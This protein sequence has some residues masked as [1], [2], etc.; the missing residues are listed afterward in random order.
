MAYGNGYFVI[1]CA[2]TEDSTTTYYVYY[3]KT[4]NSYLS[5]ISWTAATITLSD[6]IPHNIAYGED[7]NWVILASYSTSSYY[8]TQI[9]T[10]AS[11]PTAF[12]TPISTYA[13]RSSETQSNG[14]LAYGNGYWVFSAYNA[15][16]CYAYVYY[17][18][19]LDAWTA[20]K[21]PTKTSGWYR[22]I[23]RGLIF[24]GTY[25]IVGISTTAAA[26]DE[27][28]YLL[29]GTDPTSW[30]IKYLW[31]S[32]STN[33]SRYV[34]A[35]G[36]Y[37]DAVIVVGTKDGVPWAGYFEDFPN[38]N[39]IEGLAWAFTGTFDGFP[40]G[41]IAYGAGGAIGYSTSGG[42]ATN[43]HLFELAD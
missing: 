40:M 6:Y 37:G 43:L 2:L 16:D 11:T 30:S 22:T 10:A 15:S 27:I 29:Y 23:P 17:S 38:S 9:Y 5:S 26:D 28:T 20:V 8:F 24:N 3:Y 12:S 35:V 18:T 21:L 41:E 32:P 42:S 39:I 34:S 1:L 7:G 19:T 36:C 13:I 25:F 33:Y 31:V 4:S 14:Y